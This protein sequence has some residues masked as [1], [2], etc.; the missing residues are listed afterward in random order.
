MFYVLTPNRRAVNQLS[1]R[2]W[3][4]TTT[5]SKPVGKNRTRR[6]ATTKTTT[7]YSGGH[8]IYIINRLGGPPSPKRID[9]QT[10]RSWVFYSKDSV[11]PTTLTRTKYGFSSLRL[12]LLLHAPRRGAAVAG[13]VKYTSRDRLKRTTRQLLSCAPFFERTP[14]PL[15][16]TRVRIII[17]PKRPKMIITTYR[18]FYS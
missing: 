15:P 13:T 16:T 9:P 17:S 14:I 3:S 12:L 11:A 4:L 2:R 5:I 10:K 7:S 1:S 6:G 8:A 18:F